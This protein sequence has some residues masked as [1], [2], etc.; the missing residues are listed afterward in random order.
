MAMTLKLA[1]RPM[2][3]AMLKNKCNFSGSV[4]A[5]PETRAARMKRIANSAAP[6]S[7][8]GSKTNTAFIVG[9]LG[10]TAA[11][12]VTG[13]AVSDIKSNPKGT[14]GKAYYGSVVEDAVN[15]IYKYTIGRF[16][17]IFEPVSDKLLPDW[18]TAPCYANIPPGTPCPPTLIVDLERTLLASTYDTKH[19]WR[20][21]KRPG[22]DKFIKALSQYYEVVLFSE[23]DL[24]L[25]QEILDSVDKENLCHRLGSTAGEV[26]DQKVLKRLDL[27]NRDVRRIIVI[28]DNPE[29]VQLCMKNA[30]IVAPFT[31]VNAKF[32][33]TLENLIPLLQAFVHDG[34]SDFQQT[35]ED[36]GTNDA[37]EAVA[38]YRMRIMEK[39]R[40]EA[41]RRNRGLGGLIRGS[42]AN[43]AYEDDGMGP[44]SAVLSPSDIVGASAEEVAMNTTL[45]KLQGGSNIS[46]N[47]FN[48]DKPKPSEVKKKGALM[49]YLE[50]AEQSKAEEEAIKRNK[51][52]E[53]YYQ[54]QAAK[55]QAEQ[56]KRA[57]KM[58]DE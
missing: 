18:P 35:L 11:V 3:M 6:A 46:N 25:V 4:G 21:V 39:K 9:L 16:N 41:N 28:D 2:R 34:V 12:G 55:A 24:G 49:N 42:S 44:R 23:N 29:S 43:A 10:L 33:K 17:E 48:K 30:I 32:D 56:E 19:G 31:D 7:S 20:H 1:Y 54:R 22:V 57:S 50:K 52:N 53:L 36:L 13:Y 45:A 58:L 27:M 26:R 38:E 51:M 37:E 15:L 8:N 47:F 40:A 5:Q 14:L